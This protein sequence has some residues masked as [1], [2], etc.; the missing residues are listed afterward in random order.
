MPHGSEY[1]V[2]MHTV[3]QALFSAGAAAAGEVRLLSVLQM[4]KM[5]C[6]QSGTTYTFASVVC[7]ESL[8]K[9]VVPIHQ[10]GI[11]ALYYHF[12]AV[13]RVGGCSM[14]LIMW[15]QTGVTLAAS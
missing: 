1:T 2:R 4:P 15:R 11:F 14:A 5:C 3:G 6:I 10:S 7:L 8:T 13:D 9:N 12:T